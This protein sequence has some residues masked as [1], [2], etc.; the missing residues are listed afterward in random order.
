MT[1][2]ELLGARIKAAGG[3][4][5][6][7]ARE[8]GTDASHVNQWLWGTTPS[9]KWCRAIAR[10][11]GYSEDEV[12]VLAGHKSAETDA[13]PAQHPR[14]RSILS[15]VSELLD[16]MPE[17]KWPAAEQFLKG[18]LSL[19]SSPGSTS[20]SSRPRRTNR[21]QG[22]GGDDLALT[23]FGNPSSPLRAAVPAT[24]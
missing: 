10:A 5:S 21:G 6:A 18:G 9:P 16:A 4:K 13:P 19:I 17:E 3:N 23:Y 7:V 20:T 12:L 8:I 24:S 14:K 11:F 1:I 22:G 15:L 2:P